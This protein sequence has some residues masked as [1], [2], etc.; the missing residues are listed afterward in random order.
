MKNI[1]IL[2]AA[3][4]TLLVGL[5]SCSED[6]TMQPNP[7]PMANACEGVEVS[8][9]SDIVPIINVACALSGCHVEGFEN[10]N[11][12]TY[13]GVKSRAD[14]GSLASQVVF[15]QNMPPNDSPGPTSLSSAQIQAFQC[16]IADG[17]PDN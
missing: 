2:S 10:G 17:A 4:L 13:Q 15:S 14:N 1:K 12:T 9:A 7:N 3:I 8:Y 6:E 16:W 11:F 5:A